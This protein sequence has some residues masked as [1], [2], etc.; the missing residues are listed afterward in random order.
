MVEEF[1]AFCFAEGRQYGDTA[2]VYGESDAYAGYHIMFFVEK[3]PGR[4][5]AARDA[6]RTADMTAWSTEI[7]AELTPEY[8]WAYRFVKK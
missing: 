5:A 6:L 2:I 1:D 8:H 3:L 7:T 4:Q